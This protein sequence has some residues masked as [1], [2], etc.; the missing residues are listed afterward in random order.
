[1]IGVCMSCMSEGAWPMHSD[2]TDLSDPTAHCEKREKETPA[3]L[4]PPAA[5]RRPALRWNQD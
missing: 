2:V 5:E 3:L 4:L 1:M